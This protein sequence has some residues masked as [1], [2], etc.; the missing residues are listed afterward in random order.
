MALPNLVGLGSGLLMGLA[1]TCMIS[2]LAWV[3]LVPLLVS[4]KEEKPSLMPALFAGAGYGLAMNL[5]V[6][7]AAFRY[8]GG[9][10]MPSVACQVLA[11]FASALAP[12]LM[13]LMIGWMHPLWGSHRLF[14]WPLAATLTGF[15]VYTLFEG[16]PWFQYTFGFSQVRNRPMLQL[17]ELGGV[18]ALVFVVLLI[19]QMVTRAIQ[20]KRGALFLSAC[21]LL[22]ML[23]GYGWFQIHTL[24]GSAGKPVTVALVNDN[25]IGEMRWNREKLDTYAHRLMALSEAIQE[26]GQ[27]LNVWTEA[28]I[29]WSYKKEDPLTQALLSMSKSSAPHLLGMASFDANKNPF[30]SVYALKRSGQSMGRRDK[31]NL[32]KGVEM[33]VTGYALPFFEASPFKAAAPEHRGLL[34]VNGL[35]LGIL[36][37]NE[38]VTNRV[39]RAFP[40]EKLDLLVVLANTNWFDGT[41]LARHFFYF[42]RIRA[43]ENRK[44][45]VVNSNLGVSGHITPSGRIAKRVYSHMPQVTYVETSL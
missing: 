27:A 21:L 43:V 16:F 5:W 29:P 31:Q 36:V 18:H 19:N 41:P 10:M 32:L 37:C 8:T 12:S 38:A 26:K 1:T 33:P 34:T 17:A 23:H 4:L 44:N 28:T 14:L 9:A 30:N 39:A 11:I 40:M 25:S 45:V 15:L 2:W 22:V 13:V 3:G 7:G 20:R 6:F 35:N 24:E 42:N